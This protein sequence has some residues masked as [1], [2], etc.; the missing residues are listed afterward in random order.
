MHE[1]SLFCLLCFM[2]EFLVFTSCI[3]LY[4]AAWI[5]FFLVLFHQNISGSRSKQMT[6]YP[7]TKELCQSSV[8]IRAQS[9]AAPIYWRVHPQS[10]K[11][12]R[13]G[14]DCSQWS[15]WNENLFVVVLWRVKKQPF[16]AFDINFTRCEKHFFFLVKASFLQTS[17]I[18]NLLSTSF[19][20]FYSS[21]NFKLWCL[22]L[23]ESDKTEGR[24]ENRKK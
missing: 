14:G 9:I 2:A 18:L 16:A 12:E 3:L 5:D 22:F 21:P 11:R 23:H 1:R 10:Q 6:A 8:F 7:S 15:D 13:R 24:G 17:G 4:F 20:D 19:F